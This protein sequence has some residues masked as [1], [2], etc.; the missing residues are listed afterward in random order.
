VRV[1]AIGDIGG[2]RAVLAEAIR[3][4]G[5]DP[6]AGSLPEDLVVVQVGDLVHK[7]PD[8]GGAVALAEHMRRSCAGR[9]VQL[10][11]NHDLAHIGGPL[12]ADCANCVL[13]DETVDT[14][15]AWWRLGLAYLAAAVRTPEGEVLV[16][17]A[18]LSVGCWELLGA[19]A[20]AGAAAVALNATVGRSDSPA[21]IAGRLLTG[22]TDPGAGPCWAEVSY[23]VYLPWVDL[24]IMPFQQVHGHA[25]PWD[26]ARNG[27]W[28]DTPDEIKARCR[29]DH[30]NRRTT[31]L[32]GR[33]ASGAPVIATSID[34]RLG[35]AA[36][37]SIWPVWTVQGCLSE[38][39]L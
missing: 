3:S 12:P 20:T 38:P 35:T 17:H 39:V 30:R 16:C 32:L 11:G 33:L 23:E 19:P 4:L 7:G 22:E 29:P 5:G 25:A 18:G 26:W 14:L 9:W 2:H 1:A 10:V 36:P 24:G 34:W 13:A 21:F 8:S 15:R 27:F 31:T 37:A 28:P 6:D